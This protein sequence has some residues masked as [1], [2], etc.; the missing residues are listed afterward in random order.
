MQNRRPEAANHR[1]RLRIVL[2]LVFSAVSIGLIL[3]FTVTDETIEAFKAISGKSILL[4]IGVW[5]VFVLADAVST[6]FFSRGTE[7]RIGF[8]TGLKL[9]FIRI[10][11]ALITPFNFGGQPFMIYSL[12]KDGVP[13]GKATSIVITKLLMLSV[14][15]LFATAVAMFIGR[16]KVVELKS[17][18][19][20]FYLTGIV[21]IVVMAIILLTLLYPQLIIGVITWT[22]KV[23]KKIRRNKETQGRFKHLVIHEAY[24]ARKSFKRFF[25]K[26][27]G[28]FIGGTVAGGVQ[29]LAM[30]FLLFVVLHAFMPTLPVLDGYVLSALLLFLLSFMPTP[31][32]SGLGELLFVILFG[33]TVPTHILGIAVVM[34]RVFFNYIGALFGAVISFNKFSAI[35]VK[36]RKGETRYE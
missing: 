7:E 29:L 22:G 6:L 31:G 32:A 4:I 27:I 11:F 9:V 5:F 21:Q 1:Q 20:L 35:I 23:S 16:Y 17:L 18:N 28:Y 2:F 10:F 12:H 24:L 36:Q 33:K 30:I 8:L 13:P 14:F 19:F 3:H 15:V 34:W 26:H 25:S